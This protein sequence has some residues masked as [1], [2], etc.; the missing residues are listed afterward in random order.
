[1]CRWWR[2]RRAGRAI[3]SRTCICGATIRTDRLDI[4]SEHRPNCPLLAIY[5][6]DG[7]LPPEE[8]ERDER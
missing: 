4:A 1:M 8:P 2:A 3:E 6:H 5:A 7:W